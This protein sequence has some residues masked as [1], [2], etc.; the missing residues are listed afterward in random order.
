MNKPRMVLGGSATR[1]NA[2]EHDPTSVL[3]RTPLDGN[4]TLLRHTARTLVFDL[5]RFIVDSPVNDSRSFREIRGTQIATL[6]VGGQGMS[7]VRL[8][9]FRTLMCGC[10]VGRYREL[11]TS[12][13]VSYVEE[14]GGGCDVHVHRRNHTIPERVAPS[15]GAVASLR[16]S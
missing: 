13:E 8:L 3:F 15:L 5:L 9:G 14:K 1:S 12:R 16:A 10:V 2:L 6:S 7:L 11:A 4:G